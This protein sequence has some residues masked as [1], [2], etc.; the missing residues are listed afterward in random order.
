[1]TG[2]SSGTDVVVHT[3]DAGGGK[4]AFRAS[5]VDAV[6]EAAGA[7]HVHLR[8]GHVIAVQDYASIVSAIWGERS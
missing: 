1:M 3:R 8:S 6:T 5:A 4:V 7:A 2:W